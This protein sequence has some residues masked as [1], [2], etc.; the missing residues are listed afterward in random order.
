MSDVKAGHHF[1]EHGNT[2]REGPGLTAAGWNTRVWFNEYVAALG[3][4]Q[5]DSRTGDIHLPPSDK[6]VGRSSTRIPMGCV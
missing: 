1:W 6:I 2:G 3:D 4:P 5:P